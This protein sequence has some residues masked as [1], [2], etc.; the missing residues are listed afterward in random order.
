MLVNFVFIYRIA[1]SWV[2]CGCN[3]KWQSCVRRCTSPYQSTIDNATLHCYSCIHGGIADDTIN[4]S[5]RGQDAEATREASPLA[6]LLSEQRPTGALSTGCEGAWR[7][8]ARD[9]FVCRR[10]RRASARNRQSP[11]G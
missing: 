7:T 3:R 2:G 5:E 8:R 10:T 1:I 9:V 11:L 4:R 6:H